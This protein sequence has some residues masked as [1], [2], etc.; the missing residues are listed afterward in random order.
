MAMYATAADLASYLKQD[1]DT[2]T[3][4]L[5]LTI[6]SELFATRAR[7]RFESNA[8][9]YSV[10]SVDGTANYRLY[11]PNTPVIAVSAVRINGSAITDYTRIGNVLYRLI[12]FGFQWAFP[13]DLVE[14]D[15]TYGYTAVPDD[16]RGAVLE[17]AAAAYMGPDITTA[18]EAIDDYSIKMAPNTGGVQLSPAAQALADYYAGALV[19]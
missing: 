9:T 1:V 18:A 15:Y 2:S 19:A 7:T 13:P 11:L 8:T 10:A 17:T 14:V 6:A 3:A 12:G 4:T 16:V 5:A